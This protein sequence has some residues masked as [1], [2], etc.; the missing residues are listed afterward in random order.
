VSK[1]QQQMETRSRIRQTIEEL[2][3]EGS[4]VPQLIEAF[5]SELTLLHIEDDANADSLHN[6]GAGFPHKPN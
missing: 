1:F 5:R 6:S 3:Q 2:R 4:T